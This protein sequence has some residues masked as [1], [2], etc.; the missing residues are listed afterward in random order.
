MGTMDILKDAIANETGTFTIA[1]LAKETGI[2]VIKLRS[3]THTL[4]VN[5][6]IFRWGAIGNAPFYKNIPTPQW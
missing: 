3:L 2:P 5:R 6:I 4:K 1:S